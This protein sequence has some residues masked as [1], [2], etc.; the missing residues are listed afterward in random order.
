[1]H[2][3][4][5]FP[6]QG[7]YACMV[8]AHMLA[9]YCLGGHSPSHAW[10]LPFACLM[11]LAST[12]Y[13]SLQADYLNK[14]SDPFNVNPESS[15][16]GIHTRCQMATDICWC[17]RHGWTLIP[18]DGVVV[19]GDVQF[20]ALLLRAGFH[21]CSITSMSGW[22][23]WKVVWGKC[24][25][26]VCL[27]ILALNTFNSE[28]K[29]FVVLFRCLSCLLTW[30][31]FFFLNPTLPQSSSNFCEQSWKAAESYSHTHKFCTTIFSNAR[32]SFTFFTN[33]STHIMHKAKPLCYHCALSRA[34]SCD[35]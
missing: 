5:L 25:N 31:C 28:D 22:I 35:E 18:R 13:D 20:V 15:Q 10:V 17:I 3:G 8:R 11:A 6:L 27:I 30:K 16:T 1:M 32:V 4:I 23:A 34:R 12:S 19:V 2:C 7:S 33:K 26:K 29:P 21:G 14:C 24:Q 9:N